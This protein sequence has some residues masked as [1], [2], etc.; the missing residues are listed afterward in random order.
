[1]PAPEHDMQEK[2]L[3]SGDYILAHD[4][5]DDMALL[6]ERAGLPEPGDLCLKGDKVVAYDQYMDDDSVVHELHDIEE[7][8]TVRVRGEKPDMTKL[9]VIMHE[10]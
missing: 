9:R 4:Q 5:R 2:Q 6:L 7:Q 8:D 10:R 1:M 3:T